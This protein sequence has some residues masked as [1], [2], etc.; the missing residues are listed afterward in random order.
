MN[1][2]IGTEAAQIP[3]KGIHKWGFRCSGLGLDLS[4]MDLEPIPTALY[5]CILPNIAL[6][7]EE[8]PNL[9]LKFSQSY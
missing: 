1:V 4:P 5:D 7:I 3:R 2:E 6:K 9:D 8:I